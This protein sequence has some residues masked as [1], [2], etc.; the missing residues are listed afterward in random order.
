M[1]RSSD[2][3]LSS[4]NN[5]LLK[6]RQIQQE[7]YYKTAIVSEKAFLKMKAD[8]EAA[9]SKEQ[10]RATV[11]QL[12]LELQAQKQMQEKILSDRRLSEEKRLERI[13]KTSKEAA[14]IE[15]ELLQARKDVEREAFE[16][17]AK[18]S[19]KLFETKS[20]RERARLKEQ[21]ASALEQQ[22]LAL[23]T[24]EIEQLAQAKTAEE[25]SNILK[26]F[27]SELEA[28]SSA[29]AKARAESLDYSKKAQEADS[30]R[31]T[32]AEKLARKEKEI[33]KT[34]EQAEN[35]LESAEND[36][37]FYEALLKDASTE[38]EK[39]TYSKNIQDLTRI[40]DR[41]S[42]IVKNA[43]IE[44]SE[45]LRALRNEVAEETFTKKLDEIASRSAKEDADSLHKEQQLDLNKRLADAKA[46]QEYNNSHKLQKAR[47]EKEDEI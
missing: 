3:A 24:Q 40:I 35:D 16:A 11:K 29:Q 7:N 12:E 32:A 31:L 25:R 5:S 39:D 15:K 23:Q 28:T 4:E 44:N 41:A 8:L 33:Q 20:V 37:A 9:W 6:V 34:K 1:P 21:E 10:E 19:D 17:A 42:E 46:K 18:L 30:R 13:K 22:K 45:E 27:N 47:K 38:E 14:R 2:D 36:K 43:S 26:Q